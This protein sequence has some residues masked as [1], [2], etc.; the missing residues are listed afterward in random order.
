LPSGK[1]TG[2]SPLLLDYSTCVKLIKQ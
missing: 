1:S 2:E